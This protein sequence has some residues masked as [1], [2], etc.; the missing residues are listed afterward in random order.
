MTIANDFV[1]WR[2]PKF[3]SDWN[4]F[5]VQI[6]ELIGRASNDQRERLRRAFPLHVELFDAWLAT[7]DD[8][9]MEQMRDMALKLVGEASV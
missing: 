3:P 4:T 8:L 2:H 5:G 6:F 1:S 7:D 9:S